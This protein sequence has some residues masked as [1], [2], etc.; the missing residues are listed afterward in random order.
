MQR[1]IGPTHQ[2]ISES[3]RKDPCP[4]GEHS[5][6]FLKRPPPQNELFQT[7]SHP[8]PFLKDVSD[9]DENQAAIIFLKTKRTLVHS[10]LLTEMARNS[11]AEAVSTHYTVEIVETR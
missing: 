4:K 10:V 9:Q 3:F 5:P 6:V 1:S 2:R 11:D 7:K 8:A